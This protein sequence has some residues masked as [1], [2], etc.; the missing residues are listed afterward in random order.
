MPKKILYRRQLL[1]AV[2]A[3][4]EGTPSSRMRAQ[5]RIQRCYV[6]INSEA[7]RATLDDI[8]WSFFIVTLTDSVFYEDKD[9]LQETRNMLLGS[10]YS[11]SSSRKIVFGDDYRVSFSADEMEWYIQ[12]V[13]MVDFML[14]VPFEQ[15]YQATEQSRQRNE[16][17]TTMRRSIPE[18]ARAEQIDEEYMQRKMLIE[19]IS[20]RSLFPENIGDEKIYHLILRVGTDLL[21]NM[22]VGKAA[23]YFGYPT[24]EAA[25]TDYRN[26][27]SSGPKRVNAMESIQWAKRCLDAI[28]GKGD[29]FIS[30][31]LSKAATFD[32]DAL[33]IFLH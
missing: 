23:A 25:Y 10:S 19:E 7:K 4:L 9:F 20:S 27:L 21:A 2:E 17:W 33:L 6:D 28:A 18:A 30:W 11:P 22:R 16:P 5:R 31:R 14:K 15:I 29:L 12:L 26:S 13:S 24:F 32:A 3:F 8:I 1:Q